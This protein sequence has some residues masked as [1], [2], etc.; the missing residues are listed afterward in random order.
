METVSSSSTVTAR[1]EE[2][3][4]YSPPVAAW[5]RVTLS[6]AASVSSLAFTVTVCAS[7]Q[8]VA[9]PSKVRVFPSPSGGP[10]TVSRVLGVAVTSE[11]VRRW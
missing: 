5:V 9:F 10:V 6:L 8:V 2:A 4:S 11:L 3:P 1:S 7:S